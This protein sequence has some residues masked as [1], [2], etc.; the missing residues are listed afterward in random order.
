M[1]D[2]QLFFYSWKY[3][4]LKQWNTFTVQFMCDFY[5]K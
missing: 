3:V 4:N 1:I 2:T 5:N